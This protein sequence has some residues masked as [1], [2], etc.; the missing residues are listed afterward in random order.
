MGQTEGGK[1]R[2]KDQYLFLL[3]KAKISIDRIL[4]I[5]VHVLMYMQVILMQEIHIVVPLHIG[6]HPAS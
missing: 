6:G 3:L 4:H 2:G 1:W 5:D